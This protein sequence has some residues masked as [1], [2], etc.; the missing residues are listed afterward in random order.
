L[1]AWRAIN[2]KRILELVA[3]LGG[4]WLGG[5]GYGLLQR[6][7]HPRH[8]LALQSIA[9]AGVGTIAASALIV[10]GNIG[11]SLVAAGLL[12]HAGWDVY[13]HRVNRVVVRS[14]AEFCFVLDTL[15]A[16]A[17]VVAVVRG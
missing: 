15:L 8:G 7:A 6:A 16:I 10:G 5:L 1:R 3:D 11:A 12:G 2:G 9:M 4:H 17:I 14:M 13:H